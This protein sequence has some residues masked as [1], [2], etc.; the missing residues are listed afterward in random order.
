[1]NKL[2]SFFILSIFNFANAREIVIGE[3][4]SDG[5]EAIAFQ[6]MEIN[7]NVLYTYLIFEYSPQ[8][9]CERGFVSVISTKDKKL[10][11]IINNDFNDANKSSG[12]KLNFYIDG[13]EL[14]YTA[15]R[16]LRVIYDNG[17]QFGTKAPNNFVNI[18]T[19]SRGQFEARIGNQ[20]LISF[21]KM[22]DV[23]EAFE[24]AKKYCLK[25]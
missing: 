13:K 19:S 18:L 9:N 8:M 15:D 24:N 11:K 21:K 14:I 7:S 12:N 25:F 16:T 5:R 3:W 10:G 1:M 17:V 6:K 2:L 23:A 4:Y 20:I 22:T